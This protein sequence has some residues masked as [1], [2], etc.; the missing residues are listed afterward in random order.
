MTKPFSKS[1]LFEKMCRYSQA[2]WT[3]KDEYV[4]H[5]MKV[6][7]NSDVEYTFKAGDSGYYQTKDGVTQYVTDKAGNSAAAAGTDGT[8]SC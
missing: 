4:P 8:V 1:E 6:Y 5:S 7:L 3:Q 2:Q